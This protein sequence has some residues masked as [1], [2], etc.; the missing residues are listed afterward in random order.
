MFRRPGPGGQPAGLAARPEMG[1][2]EHHLED[3]NRI[4]DRFGPAPLRRVDDQLVGRLGRLLLRHLRDDGADHFVL[5]RRRRGRQGAGQRVHRHLDLGQ[6]GLDDRGDRGRVAA[7]DRINHQ[8]RLVLGVRS[9]LHLFQDLGDLGVLRRTG[10]NQERPR[11]RVAGGL[12]VRQHLLDHLDRRGRFGVRNRVNHE[13]VAGVARRAGVDLL[14]GL[15]DGLLLFG[16]RPDDQP[17]RPRIQHE[18][19]VGEERLHDLEHA[20]RV[21]R[22]ERK[23]Q[24]PV[25]LHGRDLPLELL[26]DVGNHRV[27]RGLGPDGQLARLR[28]GDHLD[29]RQLRGERGHHRLEPLLLGR[30]D[31]VGDQLS[32]FVQHGDLFHLVDRGLDDRVVRRRG[33]HRQPFPSRFEGNLRLRGQTLKRCDN[34]RRLHPGERIEPHLRG[35]GRRRFR[36]QLLQDRADRPLIGRH[37]QRDQAL[38]LRIDREFRVRQERLQERE[39]RGGIGLREPIGFHLRCALDAGAAAE[40]FQGL[41]HSL[42]LCRSAQDHQLARLHLQRQFGVGDQGLEVGD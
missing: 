7:A 24:D 29:A 21:C 28:L 19:R 15:L 40:L 5:L 33:D 26:E 37:R 30:G 18:L 23:G 2:G 41:L 20:G 1:V 39:G 25:L 16:K 32:L 4:G 14:Q 13:L 36:L 10:P 27:L 11:L 34:G 9:G 6:Q 17:P 31:R 3:R 38:G 42:M 22:L 12:H 8:L 35:I